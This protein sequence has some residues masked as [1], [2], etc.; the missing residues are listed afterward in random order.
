MI[1]PQADEK[2]L[3]TSLQRE[4]DFSRGQIRMHGNG[5]RAFKIIDCQAEC[6]F[7]A[8]ALFQVGGQVYGNNLGVTADFVGIAH[9]PGDMVG[10]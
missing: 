3:A 5:M 7:N 1:R 6:F 9:A 8:V 2:G 10:F 4:K